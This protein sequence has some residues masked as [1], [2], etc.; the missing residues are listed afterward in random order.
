MFDKVKIKIKSL[1]RIIRGE[2]IGNSRIRILIYIDRLDLIVASFEVRVDSMNGYLHLAV[3]T[4]RIAVDGVSRGVQMTPR[5][6][7]ARWTTVQVALDAAGTSHTAVIGHIARRSDARADVSGDGRAARRIRARA[8]L[9]SLVLA[10]A[11]A[12]RRQTLARFAKLVELLVERVVAAYGVRVR[13]AQR[14]CA[15]L[16]CVTNDRADCVIRLGR[17]VRLIA[18]ERF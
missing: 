6:A 5:S 2:S 11:L 18:N 14:R 13:S 8:T 10:A 1:I 3:L 12:R 4:G 17:V 7:A 15:H 16:V 9:A